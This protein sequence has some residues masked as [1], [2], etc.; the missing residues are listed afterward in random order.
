MVYFLY[1]NKGEKN[2]EKGQRRLLCASGWIGVAVCVLA[3]AVTVLVVVGLSVWQQPLDEEVAPA[4]FAVVILYALCIVLLSVGAVCSAVC[5]GGGIYLLCTAPKG[6][7][8]RRTLHLEVAGLVF[9]IVVLG[10]MLFFLIFFG[11]L[12]NSFRFLEEPA[13]GAILA[14]GILL[15]LA[16]GAAVAVKSIVISRLRRILREAAVPP[17][18]APP[19]ENFGG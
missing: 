10:V 1:T 3:V 19:A 13:Y 14:V 5:L 2:M 4:V 9:A 6:K 16:A 7:Q 18:P 12:Q 11:S 17:C 8:S 15:C